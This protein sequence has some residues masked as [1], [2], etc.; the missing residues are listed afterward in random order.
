MPSQVHAGQVR[1][2]V[3]VT[4][5]TRCRASQKLGVTLSTFT[6]CTHH[7]DMLTIETN[8]PNSIE[9]SL[10][11]SPAQF[12]SSSNPSCSSMFRINPSVC[13]CVF[14]LLNCMVITTCI[15][16]SFSLQSNGSLGWCQGHK[17]CA[18]VIFVKITQHYVAA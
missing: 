11:V 7:P 2:E 14:F 5:V 1:A 6:Y 13:V 4:Q 17:Q 16:L 10:F 9:Q 18:K 8:R 12:T 15:P 3:S